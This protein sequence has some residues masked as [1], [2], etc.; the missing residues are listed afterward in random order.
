MV[1]IPRSEW[2]L[3]LEAAC[4]AI[5]PY[6]TQPWRF[7]WDGD[8]VEI[9]LLRTKNFFLKLGGISYMTL[10]HLL[11]NLS[12]AAQAL[13][14]KAEI[15]LLG[16][17]LNL[18]FPVARVTLKAAWEPEPILLNGLERR[19]TNR[20]PFSS[21]PLE[22]RALEVLREGLGKE[23][24]NRVHWLKGEEQVIAS[25]ILADLECVR[26]SNYK[27]FKEA[28]DFI[29]FDAEEYVAARDRLYVDSLGLTPWSQR[30][31]KLMADRPYLHR[32]MKILMPHML[33][34]EREKK[35]REFMRAA[36]LLVYVVE[37]EDPASY[38]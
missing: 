16:P 36:G 20:L 25:G 8:G 34:R 18:E 32:S 30:W 6:N 1:M 5:S 4:R 10:G 24:G 37:R 23:V 7:R 35:Y 27:L 19:V 26:L 17:D 2:M 13:G 38:V 11:E 28:C 14:Y 12:T 29:R 15:Q 3:I 22:G 31:L 33:K 9:F 21:R